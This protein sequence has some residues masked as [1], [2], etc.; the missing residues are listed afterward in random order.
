MK[1][2]RL[3]LFLLLT[4]SLLLSACQGQPEQLPVTGDIFAETSLPLDTPTP[5]P[6]PLPSPTATATP[7][8]AVDQARNQA[9][10]AAQAYFKALEQGDVN[11]AAQQLSLF[12]L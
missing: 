11:D 4:S 9:E 5:R 6:S 2:L 3:L 1:K 7:L 8:S 10:A 12:S